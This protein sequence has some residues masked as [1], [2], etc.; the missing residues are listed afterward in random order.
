MLTSRSLRKGDWIIPKGGWDSNETSEVR[1]AMRGIHFVL[2]RGSTQ[3]AARR[4]AWEESGVQGDSATLMFEES[5][6]K[7]V[8]LYYKMAV[9]NVLQDYPEKGRPRQF[10]RQLLTFL[11]VN[12]IAL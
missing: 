7:H 11:V 4:E 8:Y 3:E 5:T 9:N 10:V 6:D 1:S 2:T 12:V